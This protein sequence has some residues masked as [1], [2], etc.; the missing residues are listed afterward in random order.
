MNATDQPTTPGARIYLAN[1][2][3]EHTRLQPN[4]M[5]TVLHVDDI[6]TVH[7]RFDTGETLGLIPGEDVWRALHPRWDAP[8]MVRNRT[9]D[10]RR[11]RGRLRKE[12]AD[13]MQADATRAEVK[14]VRARI[15][16]LNAHIQEQ[17]GQR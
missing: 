11:E 1:T 2:S 17:D 12:L 16:Q 4:A 3:D 6:G 10:A 14:A 7:V 13:L 9:S 8:P 15:Q 5:G